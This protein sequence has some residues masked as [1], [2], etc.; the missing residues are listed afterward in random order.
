[1]LGPQIG[2]FTGLTG[3]LVARTIQPDDFWMFGKVA[4]LVSGLMAILK[5][6]TTI[7]SGQGENLVDSI[8][9][10]LPLYGH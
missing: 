9:K 10:G 2:F 7:T 8:Q 5:G 1:V 6:L 3:S 4:Q